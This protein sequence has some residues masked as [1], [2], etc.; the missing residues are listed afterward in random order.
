MRVGALSLLLLTAC[1]AEVL[2]LLPFP[3]ATASIPLTEV[4]FSETNPQESGPATASLR[5]EVLDARAPRFSVE[6]PEG[7]TTRWSALLSPYAA[8]DEGLDLG[9]LLPRATGRF[10][11]RFSGPAYQRFRS[12]SLDG[13]FEPWVS[14]D[15][16]PEL[17]LLSYDEPRCSKIF[18]I[19]ARPNIPILDLLHLGEI[20][21]VAVTAGGAVAALSLT[22]CPKK[23]QLTY[24]TAGSELTR[25]AEGPSCVERMVED[26]TTGEHLIV[27]H[28]LNLSRLD[29]SGLV[30]ASVPLS[31]PFTAAYSARALLRAEGRAEIFAVY[32]T[33]VAPAQTLVAGVAPLPLE[34]TAVSATLPGAV[35]LATIGA[36]GT[37]ELLTTDQQLI[38]L[39]PELVAS[40][41]LDLR[42]LCDT[43]PG[44]L[45][46]AM[47]SAAGQLVI[48]NVGSGPAISI[49]SSDR[50]YCRHVDDISGAAARA[51][52]VAPGP[53]E[54]LVI[55]LEGFEGS[56]DPLAII[57]P[58]VEDG[59]RKT[60]LP[61]RTDHMG[62]I[63]ALYPGQ[64]GIGWLLTERKLEQIRLT[65]R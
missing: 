61:L 7:I 53:S 27:A 57:T 6:V 54:R 65:E 35:A 10:V 8:C 45:A 58:L 2:V 44:F 26:G 40:P 60:P 20:A 18:H 11:P 23:T 19:E 36:A 31:A 38:S 50:R 17:S 13:K 46:S 25:L 62:P 56:S 3:P 64:R 22:G 15:I 24:F 12:S 42:I 4:L 5:V 30:V 1:Q 16:L 28:K 52:A 21:D 39:S 9:P 55:F 48:A 59:N 14:V 33:T 63:K 49:L 29:P 34:R 37:I 41:A 32:S 43:G 47:I 51:I